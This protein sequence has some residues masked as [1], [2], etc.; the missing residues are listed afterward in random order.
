MRKSLLIIFFQCFLLGHNGKTNRIIEFP[1]IPGFKTLVCDLHMHTVFS[2]GSVWPNI[3]VM[4]ANKDGLDVIATTEHL[5]YL[6]WKSDIPH[7]DR[8]RSYELA[9]SFA[10]N[11]DLL[12][13]NGSEITREMPP[14]HA[15]AIFINDANKLIKEDPIDCFL[16]AR[17]Q[18]AFIFWNHPHWASQS[19][20]ASVPLNQLHIEMINNGLI[21]GIEIVNDTTYSNEAFQLALDFNLTILGTSDIHDIID[22]QY[23]IPSGG[24]R[25]VTLVF[26]REKNE[27]S[28]KKALREGRTVVWFNK[29][30]IGKNE[31]LLP[32][33]NNSLKVTSAKYI[34]NTSI[35]HMIIS[36]NS[37]APYTVR[38]QSEFDFYNQTNLITIP[39][40]GDAVLDVRTL[41]K[42]RKFEL[43]FEILNALIEPDKHPLLRLI[44]RPEQ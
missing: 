16:E 33:I 41:T 19:P 30:L 20:D 12:V 44:V 10:V 13:I 38:N 28:V 22:W 9:K 32:L 26:A 1:N 42:K 3:R 2:D 34:K 6:S 5:E 18:D 25:P 43:K 17:K 23:R 21:E 40:H 11:S 37:D 35:V 31:N 27:S 24:H 7:P 4:E 14:G 15:N 39:P 8:N 29:K 36:N